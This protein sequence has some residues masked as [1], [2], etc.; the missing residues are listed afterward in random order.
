LPPGCSRAWPWG[1]TRPRCCVRPWRRRALVWPGRRPRP[2][3]RPRPGPRRLCWSPPAVCRGRGRCPNPRSARLG[4]FV[5]EEGQGGDRRRPELAK[6][7]RTGPC[8]CTRALPVAPGL[9]AGPSMCRGTRQPKGREGP[10]GKR[11]KTGRWR[12]CGQTDRL[13]LRSG[14]RVRNPKTRRIRAGRVLPAPG[15][16][17]RR[18]EWPRRGWLP[19]RSRTSGPLP[20]ADRRFRRRCRRGRR[21]RNPRM[22]R[23][24]LE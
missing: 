18:R 6:V 8:R 14:W 7:R 22:P 17:Q 11:A 24:D 15:A 19:Q 5:G 23:R 3:G 20:R 10:E 4:R 13:R 21:A 2:A 9:R 1:T 16:R 12:R